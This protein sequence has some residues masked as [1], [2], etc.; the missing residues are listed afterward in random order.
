MNKRSFEA[1]PQEDCRCAYKRA[2]ARGMNP[3]SVHTGDDKKLPQRW[4]ETEKKELISQA[5]GKQILKLKWVYTRY[6]KSCID[7]AT[8]LS[9]SYSL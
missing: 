4:K 9:N 7:T 6:P 2:A 3:V 5:P 1:K 8:L